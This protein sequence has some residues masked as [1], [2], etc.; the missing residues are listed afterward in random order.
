M[1][2]FLHGGG[3]FFCWEFF[4]GEFSWVGEFPD[5]EFVRGNFQNSYAKFFLYV[6]LS[7]FRLNFT[8]GAI[9]AR[10]YFRWEGDF[11]MDVRPNSLSLL[12]KKI[13]KFIKN[14]TSFFN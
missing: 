10:G 14:I 13:R 5:G 8:S 9:T 2:T 4:Q 3:E 6:L 1:H 7:L 12:K 11:S